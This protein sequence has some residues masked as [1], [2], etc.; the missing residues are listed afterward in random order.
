MARQC[1]PFQITIVGN[2]TYT[3]ALRTCVR[4]VHQLKRLVFRV[5][6]FMR[7]WV[8]MHNNGTCPI[9]SQ[10]EKTTHTTLN[11]KS[12]HS[13]FVL[14]QLSNCGCWQPHNSRR[15]RQ[16]CVCVCGI[17]IR[18]SEA[19]PQRL[20]LF[21][22]LFNIRAPLPFSSRGSP[23]GLVVTAVATVVRLLVNPMFA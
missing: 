20:Q 7:F 1:Q 11:L 3:E 22:L 21:P 15:R 8:L 4:F 12:F 9:L 18:T 5:S 23:V 2:K 10:S 6:V 19:R 17:D 14:C 13:T 16:P